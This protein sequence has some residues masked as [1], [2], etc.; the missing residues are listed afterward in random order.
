MPLGCC[1][2]NCCCSLPVFVAVGWG[3]SRGE[4][5]GN[6]NRS[7]GVV[8]GIGVTSACDWSVSEHKYNLS[9]IRD[10][11]LLLPFIKTYANKRINKFL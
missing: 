6:W 8:W 5:W 2:R 7:L 1:A 4:N 10:R 11:V 3:R 9:N